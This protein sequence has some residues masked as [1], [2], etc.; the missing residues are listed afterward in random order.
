MRWFCE[1]LA[2]RTATEWL[3][4]RR[5]LD[6][7]GAVLGVGEDEHTLVIGGFEKGEEQ[8]ELASLVRD[9]DPV[10]D[11]G[12]DGAG[13]ADF[14]ADGIVQG[15]GGEVGDFRR[16]GGGEKEGLPLLRAFPDDAFHRLEEPDVE[17]AVDFVEDEHFDVGEA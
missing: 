9:V 16:K 17:H 15:P 4:A 5:R 1:R 14:D 8:A 3:L 10:F 12:G 11:H 6:A 13:G 2:W 7:V